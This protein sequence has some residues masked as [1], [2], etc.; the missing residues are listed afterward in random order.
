M[1]DRIFLGRRS[2]IPFNSQPLSARLDSVYS[3][4]VAMS[5]QAIRV[6]AAVGLVYVV[7]AR[8]GTKA[9]R[10]AVSGGRELRPYEN[11]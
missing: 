1:L 4:V 5:R 9:G 11:E 3:D 6:T 7:L 2:H 8:I 10:Q